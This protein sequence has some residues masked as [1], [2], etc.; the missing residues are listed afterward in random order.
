MGGH[1]SSAVSRV[2]VYCTHVR[3][4]EF[5]SVTGGG[6]KHTCEVT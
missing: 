4:C 6:G 1:V 2:V 5:C 3:P